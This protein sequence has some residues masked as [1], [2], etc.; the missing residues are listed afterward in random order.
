MITFKNVRYIFNPLGRCYNNSLNHYFNY[1]KY[2]N[3]NNKSYNNYF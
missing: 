1:V 2:N 3:Y